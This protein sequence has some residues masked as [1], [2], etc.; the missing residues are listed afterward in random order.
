[1]VQPNGIMGNELKSDMIGGD[2]SVGLRAQ[3]FSHI[4]PELA[5]NEIVQRLLAENQDLREAIRQSNMAL[6]DRY[7][8]MLSFRS[9]NRQEREFLMEKFKEAR[10]LVERLNKDKS[11]LQSH[12]AVA[13]KDN[14]GLKKCF[15]PQVCE[16]GQ[17]NMD[18]EKIVDQL[19]KAKKTLACSGN[20]SPA[21]SLSSY[22]TLTQSIFDTVRSM[23]ELQD[24]TSP[25]PEPAGTKHPGEEIQSL[26]LLKETNEKLEVKLKELCVSNDMLQQEK[27]DLLAVIRKLQLE[28][29]ALVGSSTLQTA[30]VQGKIQTVGDNVLD[31]QEDSSNTEELKKV[32][33]ELTEKLQAAE[34]KITELQNNV[35]TFQKTAAQH[36]RS[37]AQLVKRE[38]EQERALEKRQQALNEVT[39]DNESLKAQVTS[40]LGELQES[41]HSLETCQKESSTLEEKLRWMSEKLRTQEQNFEATKKQDS[42]ALD[43]LRMQNQNL[44]SALKAERHTVSE[45]KRKLA[46]LQHG[47]TQLFKEYDQKLKMESANKQKG[48]DPEDLKIQLQEAENALVLKQNLIDKLKEEAEKNRSALETVPVLTHQAEIYKADFLAE[49][50]A[51]EKLHEQ[52]EILQEQ[53]HQVQVE[54]DRL[55]EQLEGTSRA[56]MEEMQQRHLENYRSPLLPHLHPHHHPQP[57]PY[58]MAGATIPFSPA[59]DTGARRRSFNE[60]QPELCCP[61]CQY[62][63]PDLDTLQIHIMDCI[64]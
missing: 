20:S 3:W 42:V 27:Q 51:R 16:V 2:N 53:L 11:E 24:N 23:A 32:V 41:Q 28:S 21:E 38:K 13:L 60:G 56:R 45:E 8:E 47:Y 64:Q 39:K 30:V 18:E 59:Q 55:K 31:S 35:D 43:Q 26:Q 14:D 17:E 10:I 12:L 15:Q 5:N 6:R 61:K 29:S 9:K 58:P 48:L 46:Q 19:E 44:E 1:M 33:V 25:L 40:L 50:Q 62:P 37:E 63:A 36:Q 57:A 54:R 49:R 52:K 22:K 7:E 34:C 4:P